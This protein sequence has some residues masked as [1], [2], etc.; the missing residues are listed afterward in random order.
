MKSII[1]GLAVLV[2]VG[3]C[4]MTSYTSKDGVK[5]SHMRLFTTADSMDILIGKDNSTAKINGQKI[6]AQSLS[7]FFNVLNSLGGT[8]LGAAAKTAVPVP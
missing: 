8:A 4:A 6:D 5:L 1:I 3:G 2:L 7:V